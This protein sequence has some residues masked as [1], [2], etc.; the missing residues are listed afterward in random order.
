MESEYPFKKKEESF[1]R[2]ILLELSWANITIGFSLFSIIVLYVGSN[3]RKHNADTIKNRTIKSEWIAV[4][5]RLDFILLFK[6][7]PKL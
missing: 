6:Y 4:L 5:G 3:K 7:N 2:S 1:E